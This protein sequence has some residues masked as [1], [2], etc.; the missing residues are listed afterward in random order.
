MAINSATVAKND[1]ITNFTAAGK[2]KQSEADKAG[3]KLFSN[4]QDFV[5][6]LTVQLQ[7]QDPTKPLETDQL[8]QQI[9]Q[10]S[11]VEQQVNTNKNLE[12]LMLAFSQTQTSNMVS[13]IGKQVE[14]LRNIGHLDG[15]HQAEMPLR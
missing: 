9:A 5:K 7:N 11:Q 13:Y 3:D 6:L 4:Y 10:L 12:K 15:L 2:A 1:N 14:A 8:T